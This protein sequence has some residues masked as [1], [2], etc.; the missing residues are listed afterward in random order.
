M[1]NA[2]SLKIDINHS[3]LK[4]LISK[5]TTKIKK[6]TFKPNKK[7]KPRKGKLTS[8]CKLQI[9][10]L[11]HYRNEYSSKQIAKLYKVHYT[12]VAEIVR[13]RNKYEKL[14]K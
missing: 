1:S 10:W 3:S 12:T 4:G 5:P 11:F 14:L 7:R 8:A 9:Y 13:Q 2:L 6:Y